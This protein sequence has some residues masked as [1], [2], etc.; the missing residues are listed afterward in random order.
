MKKYREGTTIFL[1]L[2]R[3]DAVV[4]L[5]SAQ[6]DN[7]EDT[8]DE[9]HTDKKA[10]YEHDMTVFHTE[11]V[12]NLEHILCHIKRQDRVGNIFCRNL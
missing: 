2:S 5:T 6:Y 9:Y 12:V 8:D 10:G 7:T 11:V 1:T 3:L 4:V